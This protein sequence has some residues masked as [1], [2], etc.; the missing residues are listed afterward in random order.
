M[1]ET[2]QYDLI[3]H[4]IGCVTVNIEQSKNIYSGS[5]GFTNISATYTITNQKVKVC[6]IETAPGV[7][8]ELVEP[9]GYIPFLSKILKSNNHFYHTGY[10]TGNFKATLQSMVNNKLYLISQFESE[11]FGNRKCAFLCT[12]ERHLIELI[13]S[14]G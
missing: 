12:K 5:L 3:L 2:A 10:L 14:A 7:Y 9:I 11:A 4:H 8:L 1:T 6:F 13:Q